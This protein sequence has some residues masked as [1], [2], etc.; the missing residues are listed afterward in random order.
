MEISQLQSGWQHSR[1]FSVLKERW[2]PPSL[3]DGFRLGHEPDTVCLAN[4]RLSLPGRKIALVAGA[5]GVIVESAM[6]KASSK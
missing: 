4:F 6:K 3:Q 5:G 1:H 2:I